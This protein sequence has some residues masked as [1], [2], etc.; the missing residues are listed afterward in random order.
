L[1]CAIGRPM[2]FFE[3]DAG[4]IV[5]LAL[6]AS[7]DWFSISLMTLALFPIDVEEEDGELRGGYA[8]T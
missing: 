8:D 6:A 4:R 7:K 1:I 3:K 5:L 2:V